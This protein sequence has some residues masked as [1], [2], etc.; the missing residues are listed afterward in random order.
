M[1]NEAVGD[2]KYGIPPNKKFKDFDPAWVCPRCGTPKE[3]FT[4][5]VS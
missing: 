4:E 5:V 3:K 2:E 1:Y